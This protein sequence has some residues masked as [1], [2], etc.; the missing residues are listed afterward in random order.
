MLPRFLIPL[1]IIVSLSFG[2]A[3]NQYVCPMGEEYYKYVSG[4]LRLEDLATYDDPKTCALSCRRKEKCTRQSAKPSLK[5]LMYYKNDSIQNGASIASINSDISKKRLTGLSI[6]TGSGTSFFEYKQNSVFTIKKLFEEINRND[7]TKNGFE[8]FVNSDSIRVSKFDRTY[9]IVI[10]GNNKTAQKVQDGK[11]VKTIRMVLDDKGNKIT[12]II[13]ESGTKEEIP[14]WNV[15]M[16]AKMGV[17]VSPNLDYIELKD[18]SDFKEGETTPSPLKIYLSSSGVGEKLYNETYEKENVVNIGGTDLAFISSVTTADPNTNF[19]PT[20]RIEK[21]GGSTAEKSGSTF[22]IVYYEGAEEDYYTCEIN[23]THKGDLGDNR[24]SSE[25]DCNNICEVENPCLNQT[26]GETINL[27]PGCRIVESVLTDPVT[28]ASGSTFYMGKQVVVE[29]E[30]TVKEQVG[31]NKYVETTVVSPN[32]KSILG[33]VNVPEL[34]S[35]LVDHDFSKATEVFGKMNAIESAGHAFT[36]EYNYCDRGTFMNEPNWTELAVKYACAIGF[37]TANLMSQAQELAGNMLNATMDVA[38]Q[39]FSSLGDA[40]TTLQDALTNVINKAVQDATKRMVQSAIQQIGAQMIGFIAGKIADAVS[41][42]DEKQYQSN[43]MANATAGASTSIDVSDA[44]AN[45]VAMN[46]QSC[47]IKH[48]VPYSTVLAF[49]LGEVN[50]DTMV[51]FDSYHVPLRLTAREVIMLKEVTKN[52]EATNEADAYAYFNARYSIDE[53][54]IV[55]GNDTYFNVRPLTAQDKIIAV[56]TVC[57]GDDQLKIIRKKY[58]EIFA[59]PEMLKPTIQSVAK[60]QGIPLESSSTTI[61]PDAGDS[62]DTEGGDKTT[63]SKIKDGVLSALDTA[64]SFVPFPYNLIGMVFNDLM[65]AFDFGNTCKDLEFA[66]MR[67]ES[68]YIKTNKRLNDGLCIHVE[69]ERIMGTGDAP[70]TWREKYCC[71]DQYTTKAF[72]LGITQQLG[73]QYTP[74]N[75]GTLIT[76]DDIAKVSYTPCEV[77]QDPQRDKC[78][79]RDQFNNLK[80]AFVKGVNI[81]ID[82]LINNVIN[83]MFNL[84]KEVNIEKTQAGKVTNSNASSSTTSGSSSDDSKNNGSK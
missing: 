14:G 50:E 34:E 82:E 70:M 53:P 23:T 80:D 64:N 21:R 31:C 78:F 51:L 7:I 71:F 69:T 76:I 17:F 65:R 25:E 75:C 33:S 42:D 28:S 3:K 49:Q 63:E 43:Q 61:L 37:G 44:E 47:M 45:Q 67:N 29:C 60:A 62:E 40:I 30:R 52:K 5:D 72:A 74:S 81:G 41:E 12:E 55:D 56:E 16:Q 10:N 27:E 22:Q 11:V 68:E 54:P 35:N 9:S 18:I 58:G 24:F 73:K 1:S 79:P 8:V 13:S 39:S 38:N 57:G 48:D 15:D 20:Y 84:E 4:Q 59:N 26:E 2:E 46:Y 6:F 32:I 77:G 66:E 36:G 19:S 83:D